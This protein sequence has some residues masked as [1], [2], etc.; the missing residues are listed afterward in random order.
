MGQM[1]YL[2]AYFRNLLRSESSQIPD[3]MRLLAEGTVFKVILQSDTIA[4]TPTRQRKPNI[5][6]LSFFMGT[7][8]V[9]PE[10]TFQAPAPDMWFFWLRL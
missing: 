4:S 8:A 7:R 10:L 5:L 2:A 9:E 1:G 3:F 6:M